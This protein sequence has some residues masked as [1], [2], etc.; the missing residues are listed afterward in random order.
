MNPV[1]KRHLFTTSSIT[2]ATELTAQHGHKSA[3]SRRPGNLRTDDSARGCSPGRRAVPHHPP[4]VLLS[5]SS[6]ASTRPAGQS[7]GCVYT[8]GLTLKSSSKEDNKAG[9]MSQVTWHSSSQS[10]PGP[11]E[12]PNWATVATA[13]SK[14]Q[15]QGGQRARGL[16]PVGGKNT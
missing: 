7:L 5:D 16:R 1:V 12:R 4:E 8:A 11:G 14:G 2:M 3:T 9:P 15:V 10:E 13:L 6:T